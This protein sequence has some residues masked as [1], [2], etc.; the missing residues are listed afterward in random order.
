M[1]NLDEIIERIHQSLEVSTNARD[2]ALK[3]ARALT[4]HCANAIRAIHRDDDELAQSHLSEAQSLA[5][6]LTRNAAE[7][8]DLYYTGYTQDAMK[9]FVEAKITHALI[10]E[11]PL[12][13]PKELGVEDNT[14][15]K[16]LAESTGELRRRCL[17]ILRHNHIEDAER[18]LGC[19]DEIYAV[20]VT[21][22]YPDAITHG[23]RRLTD[24]VRGV[25]E[26]T[27]GDLT[28]S[29]RQKRLE[30]QLHDFEEGLSEKSN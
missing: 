14:F 1:E 4:R 27:R 9:E 21:I 22:D 3:Q 12:P 24:I 7:H 29:L 23:L 5:Q 11:Q 25:T 19:M 16:G 10:N 8:P 30:Q 28:M 18:L 2:E 26:R 20:L 17:D 15:L 13:T 6:D